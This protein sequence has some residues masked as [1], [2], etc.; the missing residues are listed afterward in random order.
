[1]DRSAPEPTQVKPPTPPPPEHPDAIVEYIIQ[2]QALPK[3]SGYQ[4]DRL[5]SIIG[6]AARS[7]DKA[8]TLQALTLYL[9][10]NNTN[11]GRP[12]QTTNATTQQEACQKEGVRKRLESLEEVPDPL[13]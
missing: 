1:M 5:Q 7:R 3:N 8:D 13:H 9:S 2:L 12:A 4:S 6:Q 11:K 10:A